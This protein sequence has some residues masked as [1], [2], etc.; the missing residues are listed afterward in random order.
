MFI[1]KN[2][3]RLGVGVEFLSFFLDEEKA[4]VRMEDD[5]GKYGEEFFEEASSVD[6][7]FRVSELIDEL[8]VDGAAELWLKFHGREGGKGI[9]EDGVS[10]DDDGEG[11]EVFFFFFNN[12]S[13]EHFEADFEGDAEV[14]P[15]DEEEAFIVAIE[16]FIDEGFLLGRG[17]EPNIF[18]E[19][20]EGFIEVV[21]NGEYYGGVAGE[22]LFAEEIVVEELWD[23][24]R[25][26]FF[27]H[28]FVPIEEG[29]GV[30][31]ELDKSGKLFAI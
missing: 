14:E 13:F 15:F 23:L 9:F 16:E 19:K 30:E 24:G 12:D 3:C 26:G 4:I 31:E 6:A 21:E 7:D 8:D 17:E 18:G 5:I 25:H 29:G 1:A 28:F 22:E 10:F 27:I 2:E 20:V 11:M